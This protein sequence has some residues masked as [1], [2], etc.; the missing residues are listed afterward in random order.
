MAIDVETLACWVLVSL[1]IGC[2]PRG[3]C[4]YRFS[5]VC[6]FLVCLCL[7]KAVSHLSSFA[8]LLSASL[9]LVWSFASQMVCACGAIDDELS[10][11]CACGEID[12]EQSSRRLREV[13]LLISNVAMPNQG[14]WSAFSCCPDIRHR[15]VRVLVLRPLGPKPAWDLNHAY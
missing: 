9:G 12:D 15:F 3:S 13:G 5:M 1:L 2:W 10:S 4:V 7:G 8:P 11:V 6:L 14:G